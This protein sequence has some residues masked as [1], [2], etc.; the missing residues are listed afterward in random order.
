[1]IDTCVFS[2]RHH[3]NFELWRDA[4][5]WTSAVAHAREHF[6]HVLLVAD[7]PGRALLHDSLGLPFTEVLAL[8]PGP[9]GLDHCYGIAKLQAHVIAC[10]RGRPYVHHDHDGRLE[11]GL[12]ERV[13]GAPFIAESR[14]TP[15]PYASRINLSLP[16]MRLPFVTAGLA[17]GIAGGCH[18]V[19][20]RAWARESLRVA[21]APANREVLREAN[22]FQASSVLEECAAAHD[23][24]AGAALI[25]EHGG[26]QADAHRTGW[27]HLAALKNDR[28]AL[29][30]SALQLQFRFPDAYAQTMRRWP[31]CHPH[32]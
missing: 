12:P 17:S 20:I 15:L 10:D 19:G 18:L 1:M 27:Y 21:F 9:E 30:Q 24:G 22:G 5:L 7:A 14:Y 3:A 26:N 31:D 16:V 6:P 11:R 4:L 32:G 2:W 25:Y 13:Q 29:V 23:L 28:G 8:P